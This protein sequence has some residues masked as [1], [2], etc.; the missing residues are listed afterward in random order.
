MRVF[1]KDGNLFVSS[2]YVNGSGFPISSAFYATCSFCNIC[3]ELSICSEQNQKKTII[4]LDCL[5]Q[6]LNRPI[7][8]EEIVRLFENEKQ[9]L[10]Q[11]KK[12]CKDQFCQFKEQQHKIKIKSEI[13]RFRM[14]K[15]QVKEKLFFLNE[16]KTSML[17]V[18]TSGAVGSISTDS[19]LVAA[20]ATA[21]KTFYSGTFIYNGYCDFKMMIQYQLGEVLSNENQ[22]RSQC[23]VQLNSQ[24]YVCG[25][26]Y[27]NCIQSFC[28]PCVVKFFD[29]MKQFYIRDRATK[30]QRKEST[31]TKRIHELKTELKQQQIE[32]KMIKLQ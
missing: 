19:A 29:E 32:L 7:P 6:M 10:L 11:E 27:V 2:I 31:I 25:N 18:S 16:K 5:E 17:T 4:C 13:Y 21:V 24:C 15:A 1:E 12:K 20:A 9:K 22:L 23:C 8:R 30:L 28:W 3:N 14:L 26:F